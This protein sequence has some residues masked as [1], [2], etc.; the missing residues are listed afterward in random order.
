M[1][2]ALATPAQRARADHVE[3]RTIAGFLVI[4]GVVMAGLAVVLALDVGEPDHDTT[5]AQPWLSWPATIIV[6]GLATVLLGA[7]LRYL[8]VRLRPVPT[9]VNTPLHAVVT[10]PP[11]ARQ[12][13]GVEVFHIDVALDNDSGRSVASIAD[14]VAPSS[15]G[16]FS[17]GSHWQVYPLAD[18]ARW[19]ALSESH[20][21]IIRYGY[22][23]HTG[24]SKS[25]S[26]LL[27]ERPGPG[28]DLAHRDAT[29]VR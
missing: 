21:E 11:A 7:S 17:V 29:D 25:R 5:G 27:V 19:V 2:L 8:L 15:I 13:A 3:T 16:Q 12:G 9:L 28:S 18:D 23:I 1:S 4:T 24:T 22:L 10:R 20:H 14:A 6:G 26:H